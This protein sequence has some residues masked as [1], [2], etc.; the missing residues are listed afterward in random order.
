MRLRRVYV[1]FWLLVAP[2][3]GWAQGMRACPA[4]SAADYYF[5]AN[6]F[7]NPDSSTPAGSAKTQERSGAAATV[8]PRHDDSFKR[9]WYASQFAALGLDSWSCGRFGVGYR[10]VWLRTFHHPISVSIV[11]DAGG[12]ML[13]AVEL[14]GA[15]GYQP[16]AVLRTARIVLDARQIEGIQQQIDAAQAWSLP[17]H[18]DALGF[19]GAQW[20]IE[21]RDGDRYHVIDRLS[22]KNGPTR[23]LGLA[24]LALTGWQFPVRETY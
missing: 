8:H 5:A 9:K 3:L 17:A 6:T 2:A 19:D 1:G 20:I 7:V 24:F 10:F 14:N 23:A 4:P 13:R 21:L 15:G 22:P 18:V 16:G 11:R 12:W